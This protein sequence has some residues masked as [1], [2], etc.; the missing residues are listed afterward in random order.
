MAGPKA[1]LAS[2]TGP[3][4][5]S[6]C[7]NLQATWLV[8]LILV[9]QRSSTYSFMAPVFVVLFYPFDSFDVIV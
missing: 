4:C 6:P 1:A 5:P 7:V 2:D 8:D 3:V 9:T